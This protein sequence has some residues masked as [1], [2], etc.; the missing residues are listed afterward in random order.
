MDHQ[1]IR[2]RLLA[3]EHAENACDTISNQTSV[4]PD[5]RSR[6]L[7]VGA[8]AETGTT[9]AS[10]S[11]P[12]RR[13]SSAEASSVPPILHQPAAK[14]ALGRQPREQFPLHRAEQR[15]RGNAF[16]CDATALKQAPEADELAQYCRKCG[17]H[18]ELRPD[19]SFCSKC[20]AKR[21]PKAPASS[22][23]DLAR[24][25]RADE[26]GARD[27]TGSRAGA[28]TRQGDPQA[29]TGGG[30]PRTLQPG[31]D[32]ASDA[33]ESMVPVDAGQVDPQASTTSS[34][35]TRCAP[36]GYCSTPEHWSAHEVPLHAPPEEVQTPALAAQAAPQCQAQGPLRPPDTWVQQGTCP[37]DTTVQTQSQI[38]TVQAYVPVAIPV[39]LILPT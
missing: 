15:R 21:L 4:Q 17:F 32:E 2:G 33:R 16:E 18:F 24:R 10:I 9:L 5:V 39:M 36:E 7:A 22:G 34:S 3:V 14:Q 6:I 8:E 13:R 30:A 29:S 28:G 23:S 27:A 1:A 12:A 19:A 37:P 38:N 11:E 25:T 35:F 26:E 20:G 31:P